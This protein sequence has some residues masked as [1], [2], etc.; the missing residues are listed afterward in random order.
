MTPVILTNGEAFVITR[1]D[2]DRELQVGDFLMEIQPTGPGGVGRDRRRDGH[3]PPD[4]P[5]RSRYPRPPG[6]G[7]RGRGQT[8]RRRDRHSRPNGRRANAK[9]PVA[10]MALAI[11]QGDA[12]VLTASGGDADPAVAAVAALIASGLGEGEAT[13]AAPPPPPQPAPPP[14][15]P[16][17][18]SPLRLKGVVAA[19]GLAIGVA[20]QLVAPTVAVNETSL[21]V[22]HEAP[23]LEAAIETVRAHLEARAAGGSRERRAIL[24]A[25]LA[26]LDDPELI[27]AARA[28]IDQGRSAGVAWREAIGGYV[29]MLRASPD[30]RLAARA[31]DLC[32]LERQVLMALGDR[33]SPDAR[34]AGRRHPARRRLLAVRTPVPR[35]R[36]H[37]RPVHGRGGPTSHVRLSSPPP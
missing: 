28:A 27:A 34:L 6:G 9:S 7:D 33:R 11:R 13:A 35:R 2:Q 15:V 14:P 20:V 25:H 16:T 10:V 19:P 29:E 1:R 30:P 3:A 32:D 24:G 21:G 18:G 37:R 36:P 5:A 17:D 12:I 4:R 23:A 26:F 8:L 31:D 22:A